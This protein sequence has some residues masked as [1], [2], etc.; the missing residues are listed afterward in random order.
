[1]CC[2]ST[3]PDKLKMH[4]PAIAKPINILYIYIQQTTAPLTLNSVSG[5]VWLKEQNRPK[6]DHLLC[7][8]LNVSKLIL[9]KV[10]KT[11]QKFVKKC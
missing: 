9:F 8:Y 7:S 3:S 1:M 6:T 11:R 2:G 5:A 10:F 4:Q